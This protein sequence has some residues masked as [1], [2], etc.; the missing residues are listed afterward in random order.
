M[1][2]LHRWVGGCRR[3]INE[4]DRLAIATRQ[5]EV[6]RSLGEDS[7]RSPGGCRACI[8]RQLP[9][10]SLNGNFEFRVVVVAEIGTALVEGCQRVFEPPRKYL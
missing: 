3:P 1:N 9:A 2:S 8:G 4:R 7:F 6:R 10:I 5:A